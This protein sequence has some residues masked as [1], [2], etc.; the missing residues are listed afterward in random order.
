MALRAYRVCRA[1]YARPDGEGARRAGGRWNSPGRAVAYMAESISLC[2]LENLVH[3]EKPD[4][5]EKYVIVAALIPESVRVLDVAEFRR[6]RETEPETGDRWIDSHE[7][8]VLKVNSAVIPREHL[9]LLNPNHPE[10]DQIQIES[11]EPFTF[12]E[13]LF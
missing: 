9:Y 8:A 2:V 5:P 12:D 7:S 3:M 11:I 13:R 1:V 10:F 6:P 4:F